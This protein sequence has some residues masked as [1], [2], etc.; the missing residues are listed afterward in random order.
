MVEIKKN[1]KMDKKENPSN[2][3]LTNSS[4][5]VKTRKLKNFLIPDNWMQREY[6]SF[7]EFVKDYQIDKDHLFYYE[8]D[9]YIY[10]FN[11]IDHV[12]DFVKKGADVE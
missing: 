3:D 9:G 5:K 12:V 2:Q 10:A 11:Y 1:Q 4:E 8:H 7:E 6:E